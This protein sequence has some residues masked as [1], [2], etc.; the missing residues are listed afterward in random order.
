MHTLKKNIYKRYDKYY[1]SLKIYH[2][3]HHQKCTEFKYQRYNIYV[4]DSFYK[5][6][7]IL[8]S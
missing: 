7:L 5:F 1:E 3:T 2:I 6:H 8:T 4:Y